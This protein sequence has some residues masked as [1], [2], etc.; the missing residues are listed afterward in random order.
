MKLYDPQLRLYRSL[1]RRYA[2]EGERVALAK[3]DV[4]C[5]SVS[6]TTMVL[7]IFVQYSLAC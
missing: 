6:L 1:L 5:S 4:E 7:F 3:A 2:G